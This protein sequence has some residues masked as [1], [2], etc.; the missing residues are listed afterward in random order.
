[1]AIEKPRIENGVVH[2]I[3]RFDTPKGVLV[4]Y[5][6]TINRP[7]FITKKMTKYTDFTKYYENRHDLPLVREDISL[8][9]PRAAIDFVE[10]V[11]GKSYTIL[12][13]EIY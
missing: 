5:V 9:N 7:H 13:E 1:M 3:W 2:K 12:E 4:V 10:N 6:Y 8:A 11:I